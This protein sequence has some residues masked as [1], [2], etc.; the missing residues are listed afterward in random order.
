[1]PKRSSRAAGLALD[2]LE[3]EFSLPMDRERVPICT[4]IVLL[5]ADLGPADAER[6]ARLASG[7]EVLWR[8]VMAQKHAA[9]QAAL[10][11][12]I[13]AADHALAQVFSM[14][15][16]DGDREVM[17]STARGAVALAE[18]VLAESTSNAGLKDIARGVSEYFEACFRVGAR[19]AGVPD[20]PLSELGKVVR[21]AGA[22][23]CLGT[24]LSL[25]Q[26]RFQRGSLEE[27]LLEKVLELSR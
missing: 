4:G 6:T 17:L 1:M 16:A 23:M 24:P 12:N 26:K 19:A 25:P 20:P 11:S 15:I 14:F 3:E 8:S 5:S 9:E 27:K 2:I 7:M 10:L 21:A 13:L 22:A 18:G